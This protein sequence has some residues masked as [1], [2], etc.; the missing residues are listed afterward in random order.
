[1]AYLDAHVNGVRSTLTVEDRTSLADCLRDQLGCVDV[2]VGCEQGVCGAC[3]VLLDEVPVRSCLMLAAQADGHRVTTLTGLER[4][5][6]SATTALRS[7]FESEHAVQCG[8]CT[9]G[10]MLTARTTLRDYPAADE[11]T[12]R[13]ALHGNLCRCTGY[14]QIIEAV[15]VAGTLLTAMDHTDGD[16]REEGGASAGHG[17]AIDGGA[18]SNSARTDGVRS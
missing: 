13:D 5:D 15:Q 7:A 16:H 11:A 10:M 6:P 12:I 1:M 3:T 2:H 14:Q 4:L 9:P 18:D 17:V 8:Y